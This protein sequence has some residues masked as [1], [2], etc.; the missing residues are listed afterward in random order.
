VGASFGEPN[1]AQLQGVVIMPL[2][3]V[4]FEVDPVMR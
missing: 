2:V 1:Y 3:K 4:V